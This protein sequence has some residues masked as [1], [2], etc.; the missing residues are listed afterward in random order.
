MLTER[1]LE[2]LENIELNNLKNITLSMNKINRRSV[3]GWI[4]GFEREGVILTV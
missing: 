4:D 3:K 1:C 2:G